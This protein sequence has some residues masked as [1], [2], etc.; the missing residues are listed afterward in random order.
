MTPF[1]GRLLLERFISRHRENDA[2]VDSTHTQLEYAPFGTDR[3]LQEMFRWHI[4]NGKQVDATHTQIWRTPRSRK[5]K[6]LRHR[7]EAGAVSLQRARMHLRARMNH[8]YEH[9]GRILKDADFIIMW[10]E[11]CKPTP[12]F[13]PIDRRD[14][15]Q[16]RLKRPRYAAWRPELRRTAKGQQRI[17]ELQFDDDDA[18]E[19]NEGEPSS[20]SRMLAPLWDEEDA[21]DESDDDFFDFDDD[22]DL[23]RDIEAARNEQTRRLGG[24][25]V[26]FS[27][28]C[29]L[30]TGLSACLG[31][32]YQSLHSG[33]AKNELEWRRLVGN[34]S[35]DILKLLK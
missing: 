30:T 12:R 19:R 17:V 33:C 20:S 14:N 24:C 3:R 25:G 13:V 28:L 10:P 21:D 26:Q 22:F 6:Q 1:T 8:I 31:R 32:Y 4:D 29:K 27:S 9:G 7:Q 34:A 18:L 16:L 11:K 15:P 2:Q 35:R 23:E 5:Y